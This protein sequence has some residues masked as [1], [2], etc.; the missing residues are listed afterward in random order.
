MNAGGIH[1]LDV[2]ALHFVNSLMKQLS[3]M[4]I[5]VIGIFISLIS[6]KLHVSCQM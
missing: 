5:V 6:M 4:Y 1:M 2:F 3:Y